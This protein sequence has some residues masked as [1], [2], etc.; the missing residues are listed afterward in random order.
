MEKRDK[1]TE[2]VS[3]N[4]VDMSGDDSDDDMDDGK[5]NDYVQ[6]KC[7]HITHYDYN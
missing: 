5:L 2:P 7:D 4:M 3:S 1:N 6:Y